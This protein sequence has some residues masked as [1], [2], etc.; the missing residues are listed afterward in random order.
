[1]NSEV[2]CQAKSLLLGGELVYVSS[3]QFFEAFLGI[4]EE[5]DVNI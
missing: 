2:I 4:Q 5:D 1:M 3:Y